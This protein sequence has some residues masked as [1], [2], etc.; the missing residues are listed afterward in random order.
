MD[1]GPGSIIYELLEC[2]PGRRRKHRKPQSRKQAVG[3]K[4][5]FEEIRNQQLEGKNEGQKTMK[6]EYVE[7]YKCKKR[8]KAPNNLNL[9]VV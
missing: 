7:R 6:K 9:N 4:A 2:D 3:S 8:L 1:A 5:G